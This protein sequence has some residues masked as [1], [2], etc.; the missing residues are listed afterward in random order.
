MKIAVISDSHRVKRYMD[1]AIK[2]IKEEK[3]ELILHA[4]DNFRD[5]IYCKEKT[6]IPVIAV[7]G[8]CDF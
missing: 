1:S 8:N 4:G 5:S 2:I 3:I 6:G 7:A